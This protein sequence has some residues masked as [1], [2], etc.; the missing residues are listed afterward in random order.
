MKTKIQKINIQTA[1]LLSAALLGLTSPTLAQNVSISPTG[2]APD[3]SAALDIRDFT[4][5]GLLIPRL[6]T[7]QRNAIPSPANSLLIFNT[8]TQC[9]EFYSTT[10]VSW[11]TLGCACNPPAAPTANAASGVGT[12][13]FVASWNSISGTC[14]Y[15]LDVATDAA[16]TTF[17]PGYNNL[18]VGAT[19][20]FTVTGL[21]PNT[22]YYYRVRAQ[23]CCGSFSSNSNTIIVTTSNCPPISVDNYVAASPGSNS[24]NITTSQ[25]NELILISASGWNGPFA[26]GATVDGNP[27]TLLG[28]A[29][30]GN[31]GSAVILAY[32]APS[33]GNHTIIIN[34]N[35]YNAGYY[36]NFA[37]AIKGCSLSV[38]KTQAVTNVLPGTT[39]PNISATINT[40]NSNEFIYANV[41]YNFGNGANSQTISWS[42]GVT[43]FNQGWVG[44]GINASHAGN[45]FPSAGTYTITA[46]LSSPLNGGGGSALVVVRVWQ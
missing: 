40:L 44:T 18:N 1:A 30:S 36:L 19:T 32:L 12:N 43:L 7:A 13:S 11:Q 38:S 27:A 46:T 29:H 22:T 21:N 35:G 2:N 8:T 33:S 26:G 14:S 37:V 23:A 3:N 16:F 42:G 28:S 6:T 20:S 15:F 31:S 10:A 45:V 4:D 17:V 41:E 24:F 25:P 34:E 5:K 9:F 39:S